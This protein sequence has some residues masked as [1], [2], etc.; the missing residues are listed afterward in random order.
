VI[1]MIQLAPPSRETIHAHLR[2]AAP[3]LDPSSS[4][5]QAAVVLLAGCVVGHN[6]DRLTRFTALPRP[7]VAKFARRLVDDGVWRGGEVVREWHGAADPAFWNDVAVAEG[8]MHRRVTEAGVLEWAGAGEWLKAF[9]YKPVDPTE[10]LEVRYWIRIQVDPSEEELYP[11]GRAMRRLRKVRR[12][13]HGALRAVR[14]RKRAP[15]CLAAASTAPAAEGR[16]DP[17]K[18]LFAGA[19]WMG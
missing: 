17:F 4:V 3:Q 2:E 15:A 19:L 10:E 1:L 13:V 8:R 9:T 16:P 6:I 14:A 11:V 7:T 18:Q 5:H 12:T